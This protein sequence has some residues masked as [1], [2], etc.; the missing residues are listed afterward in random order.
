M[1]DFIVTITDEEQLAGITWARE[2][3]NGALPPSSPSAPLSDDDE[4]VVESTDGVIQTDEEYVQWVMEKAAISYAEQKEQ[5]TW[6]Q[7]YEESQA[8]ARRGRR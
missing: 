1:T 3:H 8:A 6:R 5:A 2:Q 7:V 4:V